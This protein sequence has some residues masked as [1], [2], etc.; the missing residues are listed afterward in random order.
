MFDL[1]WKATVLWADL[2]TELLGFLMHM[3]GDRGLPCSFDWLGAY[4]IDK[5]GLELTDPPVCACWNWRY[6]PQESELVK[7][8]RSYGYVLLHRNLL[9]P[10]LFSFRTS[11][12]AHLDLEKDK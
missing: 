7:A 11:G 6:E 12:S 8:Q 10:V 1:K 5:A 3:A 4:Y 2:S 9:G